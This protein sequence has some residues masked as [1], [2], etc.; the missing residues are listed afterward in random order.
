MARAVLIGVVA[1]AAVVPLFAQMAA[2]EAPLPGVPDSS[3]VTA[4]TYRVDPYHTQ[5]VWTVNHMG[6]TPLSGDLAA[7]G[8]SLELDPARPETARVSVTFGMATMTT[9]VPSFTTHLLSADLFDV[10]RH[11]TAQFTSTRVSVEGGQAKIVGDLTIRGVT[12]PVTLEARL[13]GAGF[14]PRNGKLNV[15]FS[16]T[17]RIRRS[18]FGINYAPTVGDE[19]DLRIHAA[20]EKVE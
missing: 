5:V 18:D 14:H 4:G 2:P 17:A 19:V 16:A 13:F 10:A 8:G 20:F 1:V 11:P 6:F 9:L 12:R 7:S 15:G 3:R